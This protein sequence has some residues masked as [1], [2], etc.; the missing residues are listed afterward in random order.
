MLVNNFKGA[1]ADGW[2]GGWAR[3][4][5]NENNLNPQLSWVEFELSA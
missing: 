1:W 3:L 4:N 2:V 5:E